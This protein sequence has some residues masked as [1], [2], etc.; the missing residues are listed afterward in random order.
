[1]SQVTVE[2]GSLITRTNFEL[3]DFDYQVDDPDFKKDIEEKIIDYYYDFEIGSET[4]DMF[5]RKFKARFLRAIGYYNKLYNTTL[6]SYNPLI[7]SKM[8]EALEQLSTTNSQQDAS[9]ST[10]GNGEVNQTNT[11]TSDQ[12]S[13]TQTDSNTKNSDYPQ[14]SISGGD[15]LNGESVSTGTDNN[16]STN[17]TDSTGKTTN[18][19]TATMTGKTEGNESSNTNYSKTIEGLTGTSYQELITKERENILRIPNMIIEELKPCFILVY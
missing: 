17:T 4:P 7:N 2:L 15:F 10:Q 8:T 18:S 12:D 3:F 6:L 9:S 16:Q 14:Q 11:T 1:M 5:K 13:K 19:D